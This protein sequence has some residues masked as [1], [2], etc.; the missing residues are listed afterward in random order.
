[1]RKIVIILQLLIFDIVYISAQT[2]LWQGKGRIAISS[3]GNEHDDDD[4]S[5]TPLSLAMIA[6]KGL[7]DK[8]FYTPIAIIYG[9]AIKTDPIKM[10]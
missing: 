10:D 1:M 5:A 6:A 4:W 9:E 7:Q 3:D 2:P 8:L